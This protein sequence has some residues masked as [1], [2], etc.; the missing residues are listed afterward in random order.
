MSS[1]A[2]VI[3]QFSVTEN[4]D[5]QILTVDNY[6]MAKMTW[7]WLTA[8]CFS[9]RTKRS[10]VMEEPVLAWLKEL[11]NIFIKR[12]VSS[13]ITLEINYQCLSE[14]LIHETSSLLKYDDPTLVFVWYDCEVMPLRKRQMCELILHVL[15]HQYS[16]TVIY[17]VT[18][19]AEL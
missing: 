12:C 13:L 11:I 14:P 16:I 15:K 10:G 6:Q 2:P 4:K 9:W 19:W 8:S 17:K 3:V 1:R 18:R 5:E 7:S